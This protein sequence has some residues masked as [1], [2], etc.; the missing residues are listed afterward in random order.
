VKTIP[1]ARSAFATL[2]TGAGLPALL[3]TAPAFAQD[4]S[5][6]D[7]ADAAPDMAEVVVTAQR[8]AERQ[9]D[10]PITITALSSEDLKQAGIDDLS[11]IATVTPA[12]RFD[13]TGA[14]FQ[15]TI[16]GVGSAVITSGAGSN[17]GI[18]VDGFYNPAPLAANF[19]FLNVESVQVLKGPQ[20]TLFGYNT[21]GGAVLVSTGE[22]EPVFGGALEASYGSYNAQ[23]YQVYATAPL[24]D[25]VAF[26]VAG[27]FSQG[28]GYFED[29]LSGDDD[30][31]AYENWSLRTGLLIKASENA[32]LLIRYLHTDTDDP[33]AL[34]G[35]AYVD[36]DGT[37]LVIGSAYN[38][39]PGILPHA[40][41]TT[42]PH[43][44]IQDG[45]VGFF[46]KSDTFQITANVDLDFATLTSYTQYSKLTTSHDEEDLTYTSLELAPEFYAPFL[47][48][49]IPVEDRLITQE[50]LLNSAD[51]GRLKWTAGLFFMDFDEQFGPVET[52]VLGGAPQL[53]GR[54]G[55][56][57]IS[58][59]GY[60]DATYQAL[61]KLFL[62]AGVRYSKDTVTEAYF[63]F[64]GLPYTAL[65]DLKN[66]RL[67]P[68]AVIRYTPTDSSSIY[69]SYTRGYKSGIYNVGGASTDSVKPESINAYEV[70]Y[71]LAGR[72]LSFDAAA[73]YYD[74]KDLQVAS[75]ISDPAPASV[76]RNA[77][78]SEILGVEAQL[79]AHLSQRL[80]LSFGAAYTDA[81]YKRFDGSPTF[82]QCVD[83]AVCGA[84][85]GFMV[86]GS[87]DLDDARMLR[88]PKLTGNIGA[89]YTVPVGGG[90]LATSANL[91]YTS[92][93]YFDSS[94][95]FFQDGYTLLS[96]RIEWTDPTGRYTIGV[97]GENLTDEEY[98]GTILANNP[99]I[100]AYWGAPR[101]WGA[102]LRVNF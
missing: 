39:Y 102:D 83:I 12:M 88:A 99:G 32:S 79:N 46:S 72:S 19:K 26:D 28:D 64:A 80:D 35:N 65:P 92:K 23:D 90:A 73:Y 33:T 66:D 101:T 63:D 20:G 25:S 31:G 78:D 91:Y 14:F 50:F 36:E 97:H 84:N 95:Q 69:A 13:T 96:A 53:S 38:L 45:A 44:V 16:R 40:E 15:P 68:R 70:G 62:T 82:E 37:P 61:D 10:V 86:S 2:L 85:T 58:W 42:Q 93:F 8:R 89:R 77:A 6:T 18:Y 34:M 98:I 60:F 22:P 3:S 30:V 52:V 94:N 17:V 55:T 29:L 74:Y 59:A 75:Y 27:L 54:S 48:L 81:K 5:A 76:V 7:A 4:N 100:G 21:T 9:Q 71:K 51:D 11:G 41:Y 1:F 49:I 43:K 67:S 24:G 57:T 47:H 87:T 56:D